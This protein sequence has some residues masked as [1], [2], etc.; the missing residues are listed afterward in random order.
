MNRKLHT[1]L[2]LLH[3]NVSD[4]VLEKQTQQKSSRD[5]H[6]KHREIQ[7][8]D[9]VYIKYF[10]RPKS[11]LSG[12]VVEK[13]GPV[14]ARVRPSTGEIMRRHQDHIRIRTDQDLT[15]QVD[16]GSQEIVP[17]ETPL[18]SND[19]PSEPSTTF[20]C[21]NP[22]AISEEVRQPFISEELRQP[23]ELS[24][25]KRRSTRIRQRPKHL[26]DYEVQY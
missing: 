6:A 1:H 25:Q 22:P 18:V 14:S 21:I 8:D 12:T 4:R 9:T 24:T 19:I 16:S 5:Y 26:V 7:V 2:D 13:N 11:W 20:T 15:P 10:R 23:T 17:L 3:P